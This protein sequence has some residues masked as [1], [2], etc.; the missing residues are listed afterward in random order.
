MN[1]TTAPDRDGATRPRDDA[2]PARSGWAGL[3]QL[4]RGQERLMMLTIVA[5]VLAQG[6]KV[7]TFTT[8]A[9]QNC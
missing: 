7:A 8:C 1:T 5:T 6:G 3:M 4:A 2:P 9:C